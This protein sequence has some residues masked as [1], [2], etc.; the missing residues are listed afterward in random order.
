[1]ARVHQE[2]GENRE[3]AVCYRRYLNS[4]P[5]N[6]DAWLRLG[7]CLLEF[8]QFEA[9]SECFRTA[10]RGDPQHYGNAMASLVKSGRGRFWLRPSAAARYF[11]RAKS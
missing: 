3:A 7:H 2:R 5:N 9:G 8:G 4:N 1:M 10:A 6:L 11:L